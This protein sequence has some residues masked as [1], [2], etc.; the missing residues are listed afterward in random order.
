LSEIF[1]NPWVIG[2]GG[3]ILSGIIVTLITKSLF[4]QK[5]QKELARN[6]ETA[7]R[8]ILYA[9]RPEVSEGQTPSTPVINAL[10]FA[11]ARK[12]KLDHEYLHRSRH[13]AEELIK[14]I[15]DSSFISSETK[16]KY[17]DSLNDLISEEAP[18]PNNLELKEKEKFVINTEYREK[19]IMLFS[20]TLG[21][22]AT[23]FTAFTSLTSKADTVVSKV[24]DSLMPTLMVIASAVL[25][26][27]VLLAA[28][29]LRHKRL[30]QEY[31]L[32]VEQAKENSNN[33]VNKDA[34]R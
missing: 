6:I 12:Y 25:I 15:M 5:D 31:G 22:I 3:G 17:C 14:E 4:S 26:M 34:S 29:K 33:Q 16:R 13:F 20:I 19:M 18:E 8:E 28:M 21:M 32:P 24:F 9:L 2:V 27:N 11:T 1:S 23:L 30:R 10:R 7:N